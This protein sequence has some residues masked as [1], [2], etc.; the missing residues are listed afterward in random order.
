[1]PFFFCVTHLSGGSERGRIVFGLVH[2][3]EP[4]EGGWREDGTA[5]L[6]MEVCDGVL[7][8][9]YGQNRPIEAGTGRIERKK[10][11]VSINLW[12]AVPSL[13]T[14]VRFEFF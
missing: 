1:V 14:I 4:R 5:L 11:K 7:R 3:G 9:S 6:V 12:R 2:L 13:F 10:E 8:V